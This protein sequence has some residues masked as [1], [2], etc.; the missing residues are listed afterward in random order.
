VLP[1][2]ATGDARSK[3]HRTTA[4]LL[5]MTGQKEVASKITKRT[6]AIH[7]INMPLNKP[8]A[9]FRAH[10]RKKPAVE[11]DLSCKQNS[12]PG[13]APGSCHCQSFPYS[14]RALGLPASRRVMGP[15]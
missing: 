4:S 15:G 9:A 13:I 5:G 11:I 3:L 6:Y 8:N 12:N 7:I 10:Q 14:A 2:P 1:R